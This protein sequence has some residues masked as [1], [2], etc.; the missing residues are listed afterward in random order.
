M[1]VLKSELK[2]LVTHEIGVRV[3]DA[4]EA[5]QKELHALEGKQA[6]FLEGSKAV[7]A[8]MV[9]I[10]KDVSE[11]KYGLEVA[12]VA[13]RY[14]TRA[15]NALQNLSMQ[16]SQLRVAQSGKVQGFEHTVKL[17]SNLIE[18]EK[19]KAAALQTVPEA[20]P[21]GDRDRPAGLRP[22]S[23]KAQRLAEEAAAKETSAPPPPP[24]EKAP[25]QEAGAER[26]SKKRGGRMKR[27]SNS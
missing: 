17:L 19:A 5:A 27:A 14:M 18:Q 21:P 26:T 6:A 4:K 8:L 25:E 16:A 11:E 24:P 23:I 1:S 22:V 2:Q 12:E 9:G 7:E 13:K 3:E 10:D 20:A 15:V